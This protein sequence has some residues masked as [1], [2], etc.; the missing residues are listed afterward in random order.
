M[1]RYREHHPP[2]DSAAEPAVAN[3]CD[4]ELGGRSDLRRI[5]SRLGLR[6]DESQEK[7]LLELIHQ[8]RSLRQR[9]SY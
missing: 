5:L 9:G 1:N 6:A 4:S 2:P 8:S 7:T 3:F